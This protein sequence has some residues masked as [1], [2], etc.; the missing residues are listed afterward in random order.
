MP[1]HFDPSV[2]IGASPAVPSSTPAVRRDAD[3]VQVIT[4]AAAI[5][6]Q[7]AGHRDGL[8]VIDVAR[9][10][11]LP[12]STTH[13]IILAL[14]QEGLARRGADGRFTLGLEFESLAEAARS[15]LRRK[16]SPHLL[17]LTERTGETAELGVLSGGDVLFID[18]HASRQTLR[19]VSE[20]GTRAPVHATASGKALLAA[21]PRDRVER[22]LPRLLVGLTKRTI[23]SRDALL[24]ELDRVRQTGTALDI[25][26]HSLG[27][28]SVAT[29]VT[30]ENGETAALAVVVPT[31]RFST[32]A[33]IEAALLRESRQI[34]REVG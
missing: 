2:A 13:R 23:T 32:R 22:M 29:A 27:V 26:E 12:R 6:R 33:T 24:E 17:R 8:T 16:L 21:L 3:G 25:E 5:M 14:T 15:S 30:D 4:R 31:A 20:V 28:C 34:R 9:G 10:V 11:D 18:S 1:A 7:L 19:V